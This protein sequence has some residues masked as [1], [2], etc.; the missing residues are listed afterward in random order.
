MLDNRIVEFVLELARALLID[1]L[2]GHV[3]AGLAK[4]LSQCQ[5]ND[6]RQVNARVHRRTRQRLLHR[7]R[8]APTDEP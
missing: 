7:L 2:A 4:L 5:T 1:E 8:T 6:C 3:R